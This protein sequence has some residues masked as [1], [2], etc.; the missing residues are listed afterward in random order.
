[1]LIYHWKRLRNGQ[2]IPSEIFNT[3]VMK[4]ESKSSGAVQEIRGI[5]K[6][7]K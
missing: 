3:A 5:I 4:T 1:M 7:L 2:E 6:V